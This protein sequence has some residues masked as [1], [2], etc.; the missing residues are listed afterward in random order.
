MIN[1]AC[2]FSNVFFFGIFQTA[3][4]AC[5]SIHQGYDR[6]SDE[7]RGRQQICCYYYFL[8]A[9]MCE[10]EDARLTGMIRFD[11]TLLALCCI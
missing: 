5:A 11:E 10:D 9:L 6:L 1:K 2:F 3:L 4:F 7:S 8:A